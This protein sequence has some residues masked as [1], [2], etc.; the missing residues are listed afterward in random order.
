MERTINDFDPFSLL[1]LPERD[2][3]LR[4]DGATIYTGD[5]DRPVLTDASLLAREGRIEVVGSRSEAD[6]AE[7]N[8]GLPAETRIRRIDARDCFVMPGLV[9]NHWHTISILRALTDCHG[10]DDRFDPPS[11][12][13]HG[14]DV[15]ALLAEFGGLAQVA[16]ALPE[17]VAAIAAVQSLVWQLRS[18]TTTVGDLGSFGSAETLLGAAQATGIRAVISQ[19]MIDGTSVD[20]TFVRVQ[21]TDARLAELAEA[22]DLANA[23]PSDR[24]RAMP[25][26]FWSLLASDE[27]LQGAADLSARHGTPVGAHLSGVAN[28]EAFSETVFGVRSAARFE[29]AGLI[30]PQ[31]IAAHTAFLSQE[32]LTRFIAAGVHLTHAP[33]R[34]GTTGEGVIT[35]SK[36]IVDLLRGGAAV[37]LSTDADDLARGGMPEAMRAAWLSYNEAAADGALVTPISVLGMATRAGARSLGWDDEIGTLAPGYRADFSIVPARDWRYLGSSRPLSVFLSNGGSNDIDTVV[38][39]GRVLIDGGQL[40]FVDEEELGRHYWEASKQFASVIGAAAAAAG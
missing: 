29:K 38:V 15:K 22:M 10:V 26:V 31:L 13:A 25:N 17:P 7:Q 12:W 32:E 19:M 24:V 6:T 1:R 16:A 2:T 18:G 3:I 40:T 20:G 28:E 27:L 33:N 8:L 11:T 34:Y 23:A 30:G 36:Q 5:P 14:G 39:D 37:G 35:T 21:D 9:N 4:V